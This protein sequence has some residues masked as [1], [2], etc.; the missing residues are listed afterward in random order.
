MD[1]SYLVRYVPFGAKA[2]QLLLSV[3]FAAKPIPGSPFRI[4]VEGPPSNPI[5]STAARAAPHDGR[6]ARAPR[7]STA[8]ALSA[9]DRARRG[10]ADARR[11]AASSLT[12]RFARSSVLSEIRKEAETGAKPKDLLARLKQTREPQ[13]RLYQSRCS[14]AP[15][16]SR[17]TLTAG[18][19]THD[20]KS[21]QTRTTSRVYGAP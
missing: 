19:D 10:H 15:K 17:A 18:G 14:P 7:P 2:A 12:E 16:A 3:T 6:V 5:F 20:A 8:P 11:A 21:T 9:A 4:M 1:G 13:H